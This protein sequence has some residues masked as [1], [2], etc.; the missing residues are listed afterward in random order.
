M[1]IIILWQGYLY[2]FRPR[3]NCLCLVCKLKYQVYPLSPGQ[4]A[5]A[6]VIREFKRIMGNTVPTIPEHV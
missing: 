3:R 1:H 5:F 2:L 6:N 4:L